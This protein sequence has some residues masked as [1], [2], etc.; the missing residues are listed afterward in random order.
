MA[1]ALRSVRT[2]IQRT[3]PMVPILPRLS[4][5]VF[6]KPTIT[7]GLQLLGDILGQAIL[8]AVPKQ[9]TSHSKKRMRMSN[10]GLKNRNDIVPCTGCGRPKLIAQLCPTCYR[11]IKRTLKQLKSSNEEHQ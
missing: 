2:L 3:G 11:D 1:L 6:W 5:L 10:K 4:D 8:R 7:L 9:R